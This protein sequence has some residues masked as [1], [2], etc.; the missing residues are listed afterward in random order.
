MAEKIQR[1]AALTQ[2][3]IEKKDAI[4]RPR[5]RHQRIKSQL[6]TK[7]RDHESNSRTQALTE[8]LAGANLKDVVTRNRQLPTVMVVLKCMARLDTR[9]REKIN[10]RDALSI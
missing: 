3:L 6:L 4:Q 10:T 1:T 7:D 2:I 9:R 8:L 5:W